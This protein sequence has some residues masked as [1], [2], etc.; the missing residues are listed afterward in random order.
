MLNKEEIKDIIPHRYEMLLIDEITEL[1]ETSIIGKSII[2][3]D[4]WFF[5]GHFPNEPVMPGVLMVEASAQVGAVLLLS[6]PQNNGKIAYFGGIDKV[7][8]RTKVIP[9]DILTYYLELTNKKANVGKAV[10]VCKNQELKKVFTGELT[11]IVN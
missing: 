3:E 11:F 8:F 10:V 2:S 1:S 7:K 9:G 4:K 6:L 5:R